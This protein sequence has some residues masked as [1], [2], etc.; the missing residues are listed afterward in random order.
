[1]LV[2]LEAERLPG[3]RKKY[4]SKELIGLPAPVQSYFQAVLEDG[5]PIVEAVD[6]EQS[7]TFNMSATGEQW[8]RF[9]S[10]QHVITQR[11]GFDWLGPYRDDT[12]LDRK[13][14]RV[15]KIWLISS[16]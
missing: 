10:I 12:W 4:D 11:P 1:M 14:L 8:K 9:S 6:I 16:T 5:Q 7:G 13:L 15:I 2:N 3:A